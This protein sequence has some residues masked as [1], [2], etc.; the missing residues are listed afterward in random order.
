MSTIL[1][2]DH[3]ATF[4]GWAANK[5]EN[6]EKPRGWS[7]RRSVGFILISALAA[8]VLVLSPLFF[9]G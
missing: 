5:S 9:I 2:V 6:K 4:Q 8:W 7:S 1:P 3:H